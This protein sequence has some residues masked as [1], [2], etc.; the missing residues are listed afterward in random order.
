ML[1]G[2]ILLYDGWAKKFWAGP[3][4]MGTC[5]FLHILLGF[6][7]FDGGWSM[8][9]WLLAGMIGLYIVGVTW[10]ARKESAIS[11]RG[12]LSAAFAVVLVAVLGAAALPLV[13][14]RTMEVHTFSYWILLLAWLVVVARPARHAILSPQPAQ[15]QSAIKT[16]ILGLIGLDAVLA[17]LLI[18]L[19]G[20]LL[21]V[22]LVPA[23][24]L[25]RW[26]YST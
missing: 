1:A 5:R 10:F 6:A 9:A 22:L 11:R 24:T 2:C 13:W 8:S 15:V 25:G 16:F 21:L 12:E 23:L 26:V 17:F 19:P 3:I 20:L 7:P 18:G 4:A 14:D